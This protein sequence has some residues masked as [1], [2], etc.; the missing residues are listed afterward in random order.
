MESHPS[1]L[2]TSLPSSQLFSVH[3]IDIGPKVKF[4]LFGFAR[5]TLINKL[6]VDMNVTLLLASHALINGNRIDQC[7]T[8]LTGKDFG[9]LV[10]F[11][12]GDEL[13]YIGAILKKWTTKRRGGIIE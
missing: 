13:L 7:K 9:V 5:I 3:F 8:H 10:L 6:V 1:T 12:T 2:K 11:Q 4:S